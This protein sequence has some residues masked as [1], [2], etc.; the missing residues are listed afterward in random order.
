MRAAAPKPSSGHSRHR[1][2][3][4][5]V[6][7]GELL[8]GANAIA[9]EWGTTR[10]PSPTSGEVPAPA[11]YCGRN[12]CIETWLSGPGLTR[13]HAA[14]TGAALAPEAIVASAAAGD[15]ACEA[16][17]QR[18]EDRLARTGR[19]HQSARSAGDRA[20][21]RPLEPRPALHERTAPVGPAHLFRHHCHPA[22]ETCTR[23]L[24]RCAWCRLVVARKSRMKIQLYTGTPRYIGDDG[25]FSAIWK[26]PAAGRCASRRRASPATCRL[27]AAYMVAPKSRASLRR[28][29]LCKA[30]CTLPAD[31]RCTGRRQHRRE[32]L[33]LRAR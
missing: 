19:R 3:G 26:Q 5:I 15:V 20:R 4:G 13:D 17:L 10:L 6:I 25:Q 8:V 22:G 23:R 11:C 9:G 27:T 1:V 2:G 30:R 32:H 31:R 16:T 18:Y 14:V 7:R 28:R 24:V 21:R 29:E 12:G 33:D